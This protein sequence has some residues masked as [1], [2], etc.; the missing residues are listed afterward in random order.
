MIDKII[1]KNLKIFK[2]EQTLELKPI[3]ILIGKNNTGKS[4]VLKLPTLIEGALKSTE[5][6]PIQLVN[7]GVVIGNEYKD[8]VYGKFSRALELQLFQK[9]K[10]LGRTDSLT[11]HVVI[12]IN[13]DKPLLE[14][15]KLNEEIELERIGKGTYLN[16]IDQTEYFCTFEGVH[17]SL[18][19]YKEKPDSSANIPPQIFSL[20]TDFI[21]GIREKAKKYYDYKPSNDSKSG[22]DGSNLYNFLKEDFLTTDKKYFNQIFN[23]IKEKFEGWELYVDADNEPYHI[24]LRKDSL[25]INLS[26][27]GMGIGQSLPLIIRAFKPCEDQT[28]IIIEEPESNLHPYAHAEL[29][30]LFADSLEIDTNKKYLFE[31]HSLNFVLRMRRLVAEGKLNEDDLAIYYVDFKEELNESILTRIFVDS[32]GGVN[33]WP[34][35]LFSETSKETRAIYNAQLNDLGNVG[36]D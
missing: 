25:K 21:S 36:R 2:K 6:Q 34:E 14:Y 4:A 12:D 22:I 11:A 27:T 35:G 18:S 3:T 29:A 19:F 28:L 33:W 10:Q 15:W 9:N 16:E 23:W 30:Q 26:E 31:T 5:N 13:S 7:D 8:L 17:L 20:N 32:G 24:E 1:F